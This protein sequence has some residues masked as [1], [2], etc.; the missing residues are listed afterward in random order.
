MGQLYANYTAY[1]YSVLLTHEPTGYVMVS[2]VTRLPPSAPNPVTHT[3]YI[4]EFQHFP[5]QTLP[6]AYFS[7]TIM[8]CT[9]VGQYSGVSYSNY[10]LIFTTPSNTQN[11]VL[12]IYYE[13][14]SGGQPC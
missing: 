5:N 12:L 3:N 1:T 2:E 7:Y 8:D 14:G 9:G 4:W 10:A 11:G 6:Y 13:P